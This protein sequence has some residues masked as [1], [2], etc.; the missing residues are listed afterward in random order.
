MLDSMGSGRPAPGAKSRHRGGRA[1]DSVKS[2][3]SRFL[4]PHPTAREVESFHP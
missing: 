2:S 1:V 4:E 3:K